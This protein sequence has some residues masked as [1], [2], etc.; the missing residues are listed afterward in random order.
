MVDEK[1]VFFLCFSL[2]VLVEYRKKVRKP[3]FRKTIHLQVVGKKKVEF[4]MT[5]ITKNIY[6]WLKQLTDPGH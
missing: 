1:K 6:E 3:H 5:H 2:D 4:F